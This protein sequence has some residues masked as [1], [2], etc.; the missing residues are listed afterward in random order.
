MEVAR[1]TDKNYA[2]E[3]ISKVKSGKR[4]FDQPKRHYVN[5]YSEEQDASQ[6]LLDWLK[7]P[8]AKKI[9]DEVQTSKDKTV[10]R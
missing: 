8:Q 3:Y 1:E 5:E 2:E 9:I 6:K 7:S 10:E 4:K